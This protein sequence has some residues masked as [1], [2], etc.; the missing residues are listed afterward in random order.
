M[1]GTSDESSRA[2]LIIVVAP[3]VIFFLTLIIAII[4]TM[5]FSLPWFL[6][7]GMNLLQLPRLIELILGQILVI[8]CVGLEAWGV[9]SLSM[10]RAQGTEIGAAE[11][12]LVTTGAYAYCRHPVT[13]GFAFATPG[14]AFVFDFVPLLINTVLFTP[15]MIA[16]VFYEERELLKRFGDEYSSYQKRVPML[17]PRRRS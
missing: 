17:I 4:L 5:I 15:I 13:L 10:N 2:R 12:S 9:S 7:P 6:F 1:E 16:L 8:L 3:N 11:S 14:F